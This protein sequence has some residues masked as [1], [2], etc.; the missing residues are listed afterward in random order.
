MPNHPM[1]AATLPDPPASG[2][3]GRRWLAA[4]GALLVV[5]TLSVLLL[6]AV[7]STVQSGVR[8]YVGGEGL[9]SKAQKNAVIALNRYMLTGAEVDWAEVQAEIAVIAGDERARLELEK[10][11]PDMAVVTEGFVAGRNAPEDVPALATL[12]RVF[13]RVHYIDRAIAIWAEGDAEID[14][15]EATADRIRTAVTTGDTAALPA[16]ALEVDRANDRL[17]ALEDRF[18]STLA[19]GARWVGA[20]LLLVTAIVLAI[21]LVVAA[22]TGRFL[23]RKLRAADRATAATLR[24]NEA[25]LRLI[26]E[27]LPAIVWTT[28]RDLRITSMAGEALTRIGVEPGDRTGRLLSEVLGD[29]DEAA[30]RLAVHRAALEGR[31]GSYEVDAAGRTFQVGI[32]PLSIDGR[33]VGVIGVGLDLTD[34]LELEARLARSARMESI[35]RLAGGIAHDFNNLLTAIT[36]YTELLLASL[37]EGEERADALEIRRSA[38]RAAD[39]TQ[40]LLAVGRRTVLK[41]LLVSPNDVIGG[42][43]TMLQRLIG[44]DVHLELVLDPAVPSVLADPGQLEQ[45]ILNLA[46]NARDAMPTG[47]TLTVATRPAEAGTIAV[48]RPGVGPGAG[49]GR[50]DDGRRA[51]ISVTDTGVGMDEATRGRIFEP[52]FTTKGQGKGTGLG[53]ASVYGIVDQSGGS[54]LVDSEPGEGTTFSIYLP[55]AASALPG[56]TVAG[57][58]DVRPSP[59]PA[60][61]ELV[62]SGVAPEPAPPTSTDP[63]EPRRPL[64]LVAEDEAA[65]R[66]LVGS[67]L[68]TAGYRVLV[69]SDGEDALRVAAAAGEPIDLLLTDVI[70]PRLNGR[71]LADRLTAIDPGLAVLFM[72]G[73]SGDMLGERGIVDPGVDVLNKPFAP[74][75]LVARV[76]QLL[77]AIGGIDVA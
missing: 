76:G 9:W 40:Q 47:G 24:E 53:L 34:R 7:G 17:T 38:E 58:E 1:P 59:R 21:L 5:V 30:T 11:E 55:A 63:A 31:S 66:A 29:D 46:V 70:M 67:V 32:E 12:F 4:L 13:R 16:L 28:D 35:G 19:E 61:L 37:P 2:A 42:M 62:P 22:W 64:I 14:R 73:Y 15:L 69:A 10:P 33:I 23:V 8:A 49:S 45:V 26:V 51:L 72:T 74:A 41:P 71:G 68:T 6:A 50:R 75:D 56:S 54:I 57:A 36:G 18:S 44:E 20:V 25:R 39:L 27:Q 52:F 60:H 3:V 48:G 77:P 65:V 43:E